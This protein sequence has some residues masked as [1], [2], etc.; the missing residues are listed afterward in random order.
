MWKHIWPG[1][2]YR[3]IL[4]MLTLALLAAACGQG[5]GAS[6]PDTEGEASQQ[7]QLVTNQDQSSDAMEL[8]QGENLPGRLLFVQDGTIWQW[9]EQQIGPLINTGQ[10]WQPEWSPDGRR[11]AFVE[12][13][14]SYSDVLLASADGE[15]L[16]RLTNNSSDY[17]LQ[18]YERIYDSM[19]AWY[20]TWTPR[21]TAVTVATQYSTPMASSSGAVEY[22]L[23]LYN[24]PMTSGSRQ[25]VYAHD[26]A[27]V[28]QM[29]YAPDG[30]ALIYTHMD[31]R[32]SG[33]QQLHRIEMDESES[34][35]TAYP[36]APDRSY[37]PAFSPDGRWLAFAAR[38]DEDTDIWVLPGN[39]TTGSSPT[40]QRLTDLG[41]AR[42][43]VFSP[44]GQMLAFLAIPPD[45]QGFELWLISLSVR[46]DG[47]LQAGEPRQL[48]SNMRL[49]PDSGLTW[50]Q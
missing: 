35:S 34:S 4:L 21:G 44:N 36:G 18:S 29:D 30:S 31:Q 32:G 7:G 23:A 39:A 48:T 43:P 13:G 1:R 17:A 20:P 38:D 8:S 46:T 33:R 3:L 40:P 49:D 27:Q 25:E 12:R 26:N 24:L 37:D 41:M 5:P 16:R 19:W 2:R 22:N 10:A 11:I 15:P 9:Q 28:G 6:L 45:E 14:E 47:T 50:A 42:A